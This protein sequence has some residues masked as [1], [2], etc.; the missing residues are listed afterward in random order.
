MPK[1]PNEGDIT[2]TQ[3]TD[4]DTWNSCP[5]CFKAWKDI[6]ATPGL[7]HRTRLCYLCTKKE[8]DAQRNIHRK[9]P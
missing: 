8:N 1:R 9:I 7:I 3:M 6:R 5:K 2:T 4:N